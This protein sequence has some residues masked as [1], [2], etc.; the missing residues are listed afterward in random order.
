[1]TSNNSNKVNSQD[2][3]YSSHKLISSYS[4]EKIFGQ[5][6][7][8]ILKILKK[9]PIY[10][11]EL[12]KALEMTEQSIYY[13][14]RRLIDRE[15]VEAQPESY[16]NTE[17][18]RTIHVNRYQL[19]GDTFL[20]DI[21][22]SDNEETAK[23]NLSQDSLKIDDKFLPSF[24]QPFNKNG[25]FDGWIVVGER[26]SDAPF[27]APIA[28]LIGKYLQFPSHYFLVK[29]D[30]IIADS[31]LYTENLILF[32]GPFVNNLFLLETDSQKSVNDILPVKFLQTKNSG[33]YIK[34]KNDKIQNGLLG[35]IQTL[36]N[37]FN[38]VKTILVIGGP[39]RQGTESSVV[40][41]TKYCHEV[42]QE[43]ERTG[44]YCIVEGITN[45]NGE[46]IDIQFKKY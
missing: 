37:P 43:I 36:P 7:W 16:E 35:V 12:A 40:A 5:T 28:F 32:G 44:S 10:S 6:T 31:L 2:K 4:A 34:G 45:D 21:N 25:K 30:N 24:L 8:K 14:L 19:T 20:I 33:L 42:E 46:I 27:A 3:S 26:S 29:W 23:G 15:F 9:G 22:E 41:I 11:K 18:N 39:K 38:P 1:M 13:H 17:E